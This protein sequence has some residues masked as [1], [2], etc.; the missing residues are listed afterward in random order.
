MIKNQRSFWEKKKTKQSL[1]LYLAVFGRNECNFRE[2]KNVSED[3][4]F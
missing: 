2:K 3:I 4:K 1:N